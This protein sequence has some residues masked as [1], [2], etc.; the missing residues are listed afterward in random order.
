M[1]TGTN[2]KQILQIRIYIYSTLHSNLVDMR[3]HRQPKE[4][5]K[6]RKKSIPKQIKQQQVK[7]QEQTFYMRCVLIPNLNVYNC[8]EYIDA[9]T[10]IRAMPILIVLICMHFAFEI[11]RLLIIKSLK[12]YL[13]VRKSRRYWNMFGVLHMYVCCAHVNARG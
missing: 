13:C 8:T 4:R 3:C 12:R 1:G 5:K 10:C 9:R 2:P 11:F 6:K 7:E